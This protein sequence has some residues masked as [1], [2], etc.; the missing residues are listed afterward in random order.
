MKRLTYAL[1]L[2]ADILAPRFTDATR[3]AV[4][5]WYACNEP[6]TPAT[7]TANAF[8]IGRTLDTIQDCRFTAGIYL[9]IRLG[10]LNWEIDHDPEAGRVA[11][12]LRQALTPPLHLI[13]ADPLAVLGHSR[14]PKFP[15]V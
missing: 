3:Y 1:S 10:W 6:S 2:L 13:P 12:Y 4:A 7:L 9:A 11:L 5:A 15:Q 8:G 14:N